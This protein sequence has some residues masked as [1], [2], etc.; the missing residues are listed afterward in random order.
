MSPFFCC[1]AWGKSRSQRAS[2]L[3]PVESPRSPSIGS[4]APGSR[5]LCGQ[6]PSLHFTDGR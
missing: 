5:M 3:R 1:G 4:R 6:D 2:L